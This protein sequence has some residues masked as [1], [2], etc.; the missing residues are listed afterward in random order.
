[1]ASAPLINRLWQPLPGS[2]RA[3]IYPYIRKPDL[4]SANSCIIRTAEQILLIDPG[5]LEEQ[6][7]DLCDVIRQC[8][9]E[10]SRPVLIYIT[11]CHIDHVLQAPLCRQA[12]A[13]G[14]A[15][16]AVQEEGAGTLIRG[17]EKRSIAALY[18][19]PFPPFTPDFLLMTRQDRDSLAS[20]NICLSRAQK[21]TLHTERLPTQDGHHLYRQRIP[22]GDGECLFLYQTPGH[23]PD[24]LCIQIGEVLFIGDLLAAVNPM[25][26]GIPG[27]SRNDY[28]QSLA[29][30]LWLL[31]NAGIRLG[32]PG[33]GDI[34]S[35]TDT[36]ESVQRLI[37]EAQSLGELEEVNRER[38]LFTAECA[39][40]LIDEAEE[41]FS[42]IAGRLGYVSYQ[43]ET[44]EEPKAASG[45]QSLMDMDGIDACLAAFR[46]FC[47]ELE[48]GR[49]LKIKF[50]LAVLGIVK[51]IRK[52]FDRGRLEAVI[53]PSLLNRA[54]RLLIDF[55]GVA[56][57]VRNPEEFVWTDPGKAIREILR[58]LQ[59]SPHAD[60]SI[61]DASAHQED[62]L[63]ALTARIGY[64][65]LFEK[66]VLEVNCFGPLPPVRLAVARFADTLT[67]LLEFLAVRGAGSISIEAGMERDTP[68]VRISAR[69][70]TLAAGIESKKSRSFGSRF[71]MSGAS[72]FT[73][74]GNIFAI[75]LPK[76]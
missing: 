17:D 24:S 10:H 9:Q 60:R 31:E 61:I 66:T 43:L 34:L 38:M 30:I 40:E 7:R 75:L 29:H 57:G 58:D 64:A 6:T 26:A 45:C 33:H 67:H 76:R 13:G 25:V 72:S 23:S 4:L 19:I 22:I 21:L 11:H 3:E 71:R 70:E 42:A 74:E 51:K 73:A 28:L 68:F 49:L 55:I 16:I 2:R 54:D 37:H 41:I 65:D 20:R 50:V 59:D 63:A 8:G 39:L 52:L 1:M 47:G 5:A 44:L 56:R 53:Q 36:R 27:W 35:A 15:W 32:C 62:Y 48:Q 18:G 46:Q 12:N 69:G 14:P